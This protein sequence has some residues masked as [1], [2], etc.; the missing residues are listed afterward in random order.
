MSLFLSLSG[1]QSILQSK[2][3]LGSGTSVQVQHTLPLL[4]ASKG[5]Y[6]GQKLGQILTPEKSAFKRLY[7]LMYTCHDVTPGVSNTH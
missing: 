5:D 6:M 3:R 2:G 1:A 4:L 7:S